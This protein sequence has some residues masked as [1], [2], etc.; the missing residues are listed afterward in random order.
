MKSLKFGF[1]CIALAFLAFPAVAAAQGDPC[2]A[3]ASSIDGAKCVVEVQAVT[4]EPA[5][6]AV[7]TPV[8]APAVAGKQ[9]LPVTGGDATTLI[10]VGAT[11]VG[12]GAV[13]TV[14][15]RRTSSAS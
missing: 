2:A 8:A 9:Q 3:G 7:A 13:L 12:A 6:V 11:L 10:V 5:P 4:L 1:P 15:S 14:R